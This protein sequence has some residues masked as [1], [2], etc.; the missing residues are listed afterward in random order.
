QLGLASETSGLTFSSG[1]GIGEA[2]GA[3]VIILIDIVI[4]IICRTRLTTLRARS[5]DESKHGTRLHN[6][7][8]VK[9]IN[10]Y[11]HSKE[12]SRTTFE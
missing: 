4:V 1:V 6:Y 5:N 11:N 3:L 12:P 10:E 7:D 9:Q 8:G 2:V